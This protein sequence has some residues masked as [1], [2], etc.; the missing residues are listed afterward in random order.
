MLPEKIHRTVYLFLDLLRE[1]IDVLLAFKAFGQ[2]PDAREKAFTP[3]AVPQEK[4]FKNECICRCDCCDCCPCWNIIVNIFKVLSVLEACFDL[5]SS[6]SLSM[7]IQIMS[8][9]EFNHFLISKQDTQKW[10]KTKICSF[11]WRIWKWKEKKDKKILTFG[12]GD[13]N[14]RF[15]VN[16]LPTIWIFMEGEGDEIK[17][18]QGS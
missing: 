10:F 4:A 18:R 14:S 12:S 7:K 15:S 3:M 16:F 17:S 11:L 5:I 9:F 1:V 13:L 8:I 6:P 2:R